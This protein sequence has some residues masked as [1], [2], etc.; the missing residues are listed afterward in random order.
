MFL[1]LPCLLALPSPRTPVRATFNDSDDDESDEMESPKFR[2][3]IPIY[4]RTPDEYDLGG[5][6]IGWDDG[7][8]SVCYQDDDYGKN[9]IYYY[10]IKIN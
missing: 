9:I 3:L 8:G 10:L 5:V 7:Y 4:R 6:R 1:I 2:H